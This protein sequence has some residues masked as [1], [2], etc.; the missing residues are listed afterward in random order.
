MNELVIYHALRE[1]CAYN[2]VC[3]C[4]NAGECGVHAYVFLKICV[5]AC[6]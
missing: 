3:V 5:R 2:C 4:G 6:A 1:G